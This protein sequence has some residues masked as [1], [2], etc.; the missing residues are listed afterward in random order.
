[1]L[2]WCREF[3]P[4]KRLAELLRLAA[5][6]YLLE[7]MRPQIAY[8]PSAIKILAVTRYGH[9]TVYADVVG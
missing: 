2:L 3:S 1:M 9:I 4:C 7:R 5:T 8:M 6:E